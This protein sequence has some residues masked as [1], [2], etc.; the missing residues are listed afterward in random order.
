M[1]K[2]TPKAVERIKSVFLLGISSNFT[3]LAGLVLVWIILVRSQAVSGFWPTLLMVLS[4]TPI[5]MADAINNYCLGRVKLE[6]DKNWDDIQITRKGRQAVAANH[7]I[8]RVASI[9]P[10]YL[11]AGAVLAQLIAPG[12]IQVKLKMAFLAAFILHF[13][14]ATWVLNSCIAPRLPGYGG[15]R[16]F[17]RTLISAVAFYFWFVYFFGKLDHAVENSQLISAGL[18]FVNGMFYFLLNAFLHPLPTRYSLLRP[19]HPLKK[20]AFFNVEILD[21]L[22]LK[23]LK[24]SQAIH[25]ICAKICSETVLIKHENMRLP[26]LE[27]PLFHA[28]GTALACNDGS[29]VMLVLDSEVKKGIHRSLISITSDG[30]TIITTDFGARQ[31]KFPKNISY[32]SCA[33]ELSA[34]ELLNLHRQFLAGRQTENLKSGTAG[35]LENLVKSI[36]KFLETNAASKSAE[37]VKQPGNAVVREKTDE[38]S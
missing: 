15:R 25:E 23:N 9:I 26:L 3:T 35:K 37:Q 8:F 27:L 2:V 5:F 17:W 10:A 31:A 19:Q 6:H 14:R 22:Q 7:H 30:H 20:E 12:E 28:W 33:K 38:T 13:S 34:Q 16:L 11:L 4:F 29:A 36:I 24:N 18:V 21:D 32:K 1:K